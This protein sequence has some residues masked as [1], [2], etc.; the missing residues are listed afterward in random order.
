MI[1]SLLA[2]IYIT[3][4]F[5]RLSARYL[6]EIIKGNQAGYFWQQVENYAAQ[7]KRED[8]VFSVDCRFLY[9]HYFLKQHVRHFAINSGDDVYEALR[10][11][12]ALSGE[13]HDFFVTGND[14]KPLNSEPMILLKE[15]FERLH[16]LKPN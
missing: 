6:L 7:F 12:I 14:I 4:F 1:K 8:G 13:L 11:Y 10:N 2:N 9:D 16:R 5:K 3:Y 15:A